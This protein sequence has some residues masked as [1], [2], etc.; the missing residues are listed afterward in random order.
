MKKCLI[1]C[2]TIWLIFLIFVV[3]PI[4]F[5]PK[6]L[7]GDL[8]KYKA[9]SKYTE[10]EVID[11]V[12]LY[13]SETTK[14]NWK[15]S[16]KVID[17][18]PLEVCVRSWNVCEKYKTIEDA[19]QYA[20]EVTDTTTDTLEARIIVEDKYKKNGKLISNIYVDE[21]YYDGEYKERYQQLLSLLNSYDSML[22]L[23]FNDE[24]A[25][26]ETKK[27]Q[28]GFI[29]SPNVA[30]IESL[31]NKLT[32]EPNKYYWDFIITNNKDVFAYTFL[33]N[34][35]GYNNIFDKY[36][37]IDTMNK[38]DLSAFNNDSNVLIENS[39]KDGVT[40][41]NSILKKYEEDR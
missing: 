5:I 18:K 22:Y 10:N 1:F 9:V 32:K 34:M 38:V 7:S 28:Y 17:K 19:Y 14:D 3:L 33:G 25:F 2:V 41:V 12:N 36:N 39:S 16:Y 20:V 8:D 4:I 26:G 15:Y 29:Y 23:L 40:I 37:V 30:D 13:V 6:L 31:L 21:I 27:I 11:L 24:T 35:N